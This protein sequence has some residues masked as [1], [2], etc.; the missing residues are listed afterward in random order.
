[1]TFPRQTLLNR[2][3]VAA[4]TLL[5]VGA[6]GGALTTSSASAYDFVL[7]FETDSQGNT[8]DANQLDT[9][10]NG[11]R[12]NV[13]DLWSDIGSPLLATLSVV[14]RPWASSIA[15]ASL[16]MTVSP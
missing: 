4:S 10:G 15:T 13:G 5:I 6:V 3:K 1:M 8:L 11:N 7:D 2:I 9:H 14:M 16:T 12:V